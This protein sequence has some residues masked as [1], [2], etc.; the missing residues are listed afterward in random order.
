MSFDDEHA[1]CFFE[2]QPRTPEEEYRA[3]RAIWVSCCGA[4]RY[5]GSDLNVIARLESLEAGRVATA[6][7]FAIDSSESAPNVLRRIGENMSS[8]YP[9]STMSDVASTHRGDSSWLV[10]Q[11]PGIPGENP[12][13][14]VKLTLSMAWDGERRRLISIECA[15][16][17][18]KSAA[19]LQLSDAL[20]K[21]PGLADFRWYLEVG[22]RHWQ[23]LPG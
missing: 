4:V 2:R 16:S 8:A 22:S 3:I 15:A 6:V 7:T 10:F 19:A 9:G 18:Q 14:G 17:I 1:S 13:P 20:E 11:W 5:G 21:T 23:E 12:L